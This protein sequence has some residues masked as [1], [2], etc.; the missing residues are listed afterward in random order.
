MLEIKSYDK[1]KSQNKLSEEVSIE[2]TPHK[3]VKL[4]FNTEIKRVAKKKTSFMETIESPEAPER[5][6]VVNLKLK[7]SE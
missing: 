7:E 2:K 1:F 3:K 6:V 5:A 4:E